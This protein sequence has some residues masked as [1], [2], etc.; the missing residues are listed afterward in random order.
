VAGQHDPRFAS[1][2]SDGDH[3]AMPV[4]LDLIGVRLDPG[5]NQVL[6]GA[7][8]SRWTGR[9]EK[10]FEKRQRSFVHEGLT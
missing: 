2:I 8:K 7:L 3:V 9:F 6:Y 5:S 1:R 10:A 4:G